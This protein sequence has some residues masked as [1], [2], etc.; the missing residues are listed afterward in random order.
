MTSDARDALVVLRRLPLPLL[1]GFVL[2]AVFWPTEW[3][4][5][6]RYSQD[7]FIPL[8][9]GYILVV[10]G[11]TK[12]R[13]GTFAPDRDR[14]KLWAL[15]VLSVPFWWMYEGF[16]HFLRNWRYVT[17]HRH[18]TLAWDFVATLCFATV[19]PALFV[20]AGFLRTFRAFGRVRMS[21]PLS[22]P[23]AALPAISGVG[24]LAL[25]LALAWPHEAFMLVWPG[26]FLLLDPWNA[27]SGR[28]SLLQD[29]R[30]GRL[31]TVLTLTVSGLLCG[32][33]WEFWN[34]WAKC[35]WVYHVPYVGSPRLFEMPLLGYLGY[36]PFAWAA[37]AF[38]H[39]AEGLWQGVRAHGR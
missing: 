36:I 33:V 27:L 8:W 34:Y 21:R 2:L 14:T 4:I 26:I 16:N 32:F 9:V 29:L 23:D 24:I 19:L 39:A 11:F 5:S 12:L 17:A 31:D 35:K 28:S 37:Y 25:A 7:N 10:A 18:G 30:L 20:T 6:S 1:A 38:C 15:F 22:I 3:L 13:A